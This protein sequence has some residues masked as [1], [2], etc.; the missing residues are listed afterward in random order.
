MSDDYKEGE[1]L[2]NPTTG[3]KIQLVRGQWK[4]VLADLKDRVVAPVAA[5]PAQTAPQPAVTAEGFGRGLRLGVRDVMSGA[6]GVPALAADVATLPFAGAY[7]LGRSLYNKATG[8]TGGTVPL[9]G[10]TGQQFEQVLTAAGYPEAETPS[11]RVLSAATR[12]VSGVATGMGAGKALESVG[13]P[14]A[15]K[16][17]DLL[18]SAPRRQLAI[19]A[20]SPVSGA[21]VKEAGGGPVAQTAAELVTGGIIGGRPTR[22][23]VPA[24]VTTEDLAKASS[25]AY[26]K[27]KELGAVFKPSAYDDFVDKLLP[28]VKEEGFDVGLHDKAAAV[29]KRLESEKGQPHTLENMEIL[30]RVVKG[31]AGSPDKDERRIGMLIQNKLDNFVQQ[32]GP[33]TLLSG[34]ASA[35][36]ALKEARNL[37]SRKS[38]AE[39][40]ED[41]I[42]RAKLSAPNFSASGMENA[43]RTEFRA[44]AKNPNRMRGFS[45]DEQDAIRKVAMGGPIENVLR[46]VGKFAIRGPV[47]GGLSVGAGGMVFG[48]SGMVAVP[49]IGEAARF[50]ASV[51]TRRNAQLAAELM[52]QGK[53]PIP[54][55]TNRKDLASAL[56]AMMEAEAGQQ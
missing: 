24:G 53:L 46:A 40:I 43:L 7:N 26:T 1:I 47:S 13:T 38:K 29:L 25:A 4:P 27:A 17:A 14:A 54:P 51:M 20:A 8:Q 5:Q 9:I 44:V 28:A 55:G 22:T 15:K 18:T 39:T 3:E 31:A 52:R 23:N 32:A 36:D 34:D 42:D 49:A 35:V 33:E 48:P 2:V 50:G 56:A 16:L 10:R 6:M 45:P 30:R 19:G 11:E 37:Y 12:G 41:L 21:L